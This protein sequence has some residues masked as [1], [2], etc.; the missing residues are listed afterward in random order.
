VEFVT[1]YHHQIGGARLSKKQALPGAVD[2]E[3][4]GEWI[5]WDWRGEEQ[6][7]KGVSGIG[8]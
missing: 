7:Q 4:D 3:D 6:Q 2:E 8:A 5:S 1:G